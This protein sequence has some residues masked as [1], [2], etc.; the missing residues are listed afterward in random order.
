MENFVLRFSTA[1]LSSVIAFHIA[2]R[3]WEKIY[4]RHHPEGGLGIAAGGL[5]QFF[6]AGSLAA[7]ACFVL[8][9]FLMGLKFPIFNRRGS[10]DSK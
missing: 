2:A 10:K 3:E 9:F 8:V 1:L 4:L 6:W 7:L 5:F